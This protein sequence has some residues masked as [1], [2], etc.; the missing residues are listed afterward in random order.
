MEQYTAETLAAYREAPRF[1]EEHANLERAAI[2]GGYARRQLFELIQNGSDELIGS[3]GRVEVVLTEDALYCANEGKPL[4]VAGAGALLMSHLSSK[5]GVEIGRFG[6]G[7]K[8]VLGI[9]NRPAIFSRSGS[10]GFD[11]DLA[12]ARI[13]ESVKTVRRVPILRVGTALDPQEA[14][15]SDPC[16]AEM[17]SWATTVVRL[18]RDVADSSWLADDIR[19]FP[20]QFLLFSQHVSELTLDD[21][22]ADV[23]RVI[24]SRRSKKE[25]VLEEGKSESHWRVFSREH[26]PT[27]AARRDGGAMADRDRI[28]L[29]WAVPTRRGRRGEFWAFFPTLDQTTLSGVINAPWKLNEDRTRIIDGPFNRELIEEVTSMVFESLEELCPKEDPGVLLELVPARGRETAGWADDTLTKEF[30][31]RAKYHAT[32]PDQTGELQFPSRLNLHPEGIPRSVLDLWSKQPDR[33]E[34][35]AHPSIETRE[36]RPRV[37]MYMDVKGAGSVAEWLEALIGKDPVAGSISALRVAGALLAESYEFRDEVRKAAIVLTEAGELVSPE[38]TQL[39][40]RAPLPLE[41]AATYVH[42]EVAKATGASGSLSLLGIHEVDAFRLLSSLVQNVSTKWSSEDWDTLWGLVRKSPEGDVQRLFRDAGLTSDRLR[43]RNRDGV[44]VPLVTVLLPGEIV[45]ESPDDHEATLD[46]GFHHAEGDLLRALGGVAGPGADGGSKNEPFF[47]NYHRLTLNGYLKKLEGTGSAPSTQLLGF[48]E[49]KFAGPLSPLESLSPRSRVRYTMALLNSARDLEP[50]TF[51]HQSQARY[52]E[53]PYPNPVVWMIRKHGILETSLGARTV[54]TSVG[55]GLADYADLLPVAR[56]S[57]SAASALKLPSTL[58]TLTDAHWEGLEE[59]LAGL[60]DDSVLVAGYALASASG[61]PAPDLMRCRVGPAHD[62]RLPAEIV[63]TSDPELARALVDM[64]QPFLF[65]SDPGAATS[66]IEQWGLQEAGSSVQSE[67]SF[68]PSGEPEAIGDVY[69]ML[70]LRLSPPQRELVLVRCSELSVRH[71][72]DN[73]QTSAVRQFVVQAPTVYAS[74]LLRD[75][76]VLRELSR[77]LGLGLT[78]PDIDA[79]VRNLDAQKVS[80]LRA[81]IRKAPDDVE[82]LLRA[83]GVEHLRSRLSQPLMAAVEAIDGPL[84]DRGVAELALVVHGINV[85]KEHSDA[86]GEKDLTPPVQWAGSRRAAAFVKELGFAPQFAGFEARKLDRFLEVEGPPDLGPLHDYQEIVVDDIRKLVRMKP[87]SRGLLSLPTGAGKT[88]VTIEALVQSIVASEL[89]SP[90]LWVAQT[91]ELC[92]QAVQTWSEIWRALGPSGERLTISRLWSNLSADEVEQGHQVVVATIAKL[93]AGVMTSS[94]YDWLASA[95]C[96]VV[97]EA[98]QSIGTSY[99]D[100]LRWQ[101]M[102]RG[103]ERIP[104]LGLTATPFRGTNEPETKLLI[105]RYGKHRLDVNALG[106]ESAYP[107]LQS[108]GILAQVDHELL[109]GSE[110]ELSEDDLRRLKQFQRLPEGPSQRLG[111]DV[112]RNRTLLESISE[113]DDSWPVLLFAVSV[114]HAQTLAALLTRE[115]IPAAA[116][117]GA[118]DRTARRYYVE[119]FRR[120]ELRV[121][122]NFNVLAAGFDAPKVRALYVARPTY[123]PNA[124]QQMIGRGLRGPRNGG[125]DRC[126]LVNVADNVARFEHRLAFHEFDYLWGAEEPMAA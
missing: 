9:T 44:Y 47:N 43:V 99:T 72:T 58:D 81:K 21:R 52:P 95:S 103:A 98:H 53:R 94:A 49:R 17:M 111:S 56:C 122:T 100:L 18:P 91:E 31:E 74:S 78:D 29:V 102:G 65:A 71:F 62:L 41:V 3:R 54:A 7:F 123:A 4:S 30:N 105:S 108:I 15:A 116:I 26:E 8:S 57:D 113:L 110:I 120:G 6:L 96:L 77:A 39:F 69:P 126:L 60:D 25:L 23:R 88:R 55:P 63:A 14:R 36:R 84:D 83:I 16:L 66:L 13:E 42:R 115:G 33:P 90:V 46:M 87:K 86:L 76:E 12:R 118:M 51:G 106:R 37:E 112:E 82:R 2:E 48:R 114:E 109:P 97:D 73:G 20:E 93:D 117:T 45:A 22:T 79:V 61:R 38:G 35:W 10:I 89:G 40:V 27:D 104:L 101:G 75:D 24:R 64:S 34:A 68:V 124:Y 107:H 125:T 119:Q 85:L 92:E 67:V 59:R 70:R 121:L 32:V 5:T 1:V 50:W 11:P 19:D 80:K 28:P